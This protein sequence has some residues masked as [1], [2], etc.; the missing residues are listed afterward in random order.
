VNPV[1]IIGAGDLGCET[2]ALVERINAASS[3]PMWTLRGLLDDDPARHNSHVRSVPVLGGC[4]WLDAYPEVACVIAVGHSDVRQR[5]A[6]QIPASCASAGALVDPSVH[7]PRTASVAEGTILY[8]GSVLM[9]NVTLHAHTIVDAQCT[10]GHD[11]VLESFATLHPGVR[12]SGHVHI[13]T[14]ARLGAGSVVLPQCHVG[15]GATVGAGAVV[16]K[17]VPPGAT[18][19]GVPARVVS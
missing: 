11:A 12:L 8:A 10:L 4:D 2:V 1:V 3:D 6:A 17:D 16:T 19:V 13:G 14:G 7:V 15:A 5:V 9:E 18:V